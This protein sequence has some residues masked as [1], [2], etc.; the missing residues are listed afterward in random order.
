MTP[1]RVL[2]LQ[3]EVGGGHKVP[4][5]AVKESIERLHPGRYEVEVVDF[6]GACG[7]P[8]AER[9]IKGAWDYALAHPWSARLSYFLVDTLRPLVRFYLPLMIPELI[10]K[11]VPWIRDRA[12]DVVFST[13]YLCTDV[14]VRARRASGL[15]YRIVQ[16]A[17][18]PWDAFHWWAIQGVDVHCGASERATKMLVDRGIP[19]DRVRRV[20]FPVRRRFLEPVADP[21]AV[22]ARLGL[23]PDRPTLLFTL[24]N[25]GIGPTLGW[26]E[27]IHRRGLPCNLL[28]VCGRSAPALERIRAVA[29]TPSDSNTVPLGFVED[30]HEL[31]AVTDLVIQKAGACTTME[32]LVT[33]NPIVFTAAAAQNETPNVDF[34]VRHDVGWYTP[35]RA[36]FFALLDRLLVGD[37]LA[38]ARARVRALDLPVGGDG[39]AEV[40]L[41]GIA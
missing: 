31:L 34:C 37:E 6:P 22:R 38:Q 8:G 15:P 36:S 18:D 12:P 26:A 5:L 29:A 2:M 21:A 33:G 7:A 10:E 4:A 16:F 11:G 17:I 41:E 9:H 35:E 1:K 13:H 39:L 28:C 40:V 23:R 19:A 27:E 14:A 30:M 24:G 32:S 20:P 3:I 25:Q